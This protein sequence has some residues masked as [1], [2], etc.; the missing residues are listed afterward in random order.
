MGLDMNRLN[1]ICLLLAVGIFSKS[2]IAEI[3][4]VTGEIFSQHHD[5]TIKSQGFIV[6]FQQ[7]TLAAQ[8]VGDIN[9]VSEKFEAGVMV[10][11][12]TVLFSTDRTNYITQVAEAKQA[13]IEARLALADEKVRADRAKKDWRMTQSSEPN[14]LA[15]RDL[16]VDAAKAALEA[17]TSRLAKAERDLTLTEIRAP[18]D[19]VVKS[20]E[21]SLGDLMMPGT[22]A[23][24]FIQADVATLDLPIRLGELALINNVD[25]LRIEVSSINAGREGNSPAPS[26]LAVPVSLSADVNKQ[27]QQ[28]RLRVKVPLTFTGDNK[29]FVNQYVVAKVVIPSKDKLFAI[30]EEVFTQRN[31]ILSV[32][33]GVITE[34]FPEVVYEYKGKKFCVLNDLD[35]INV[36]T[37]TPD[38]Y[39]SG[40]EVNPVKIS[41]F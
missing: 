9:Y 8:V 5:I 20:R 30:P 35:S 29:L 27:E 32:S 40:A 10:E 24:S 21:V 2:A 25:V 23:G 36:I 4:V 22:I 3:D 12:G 6:P 28:A 7:T 31:S 18:Y 15:G 13:V 38:L 16:Y 34:K 26:V 11:K 37:E 39:W 19:G 1:I 33:G 41:M 17:A 14:E